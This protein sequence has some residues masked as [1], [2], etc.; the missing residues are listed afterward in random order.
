MLHN[1]GGVTQGG[2]HGP[3]SHNV[4]ADEGPGLASLGR[5]AAPGLFRIGRFVVAALD[6]AD[7]RVLCAYSHAEVQKSLKLAVGHY[8]KQF[9]HVNATNIVTLIYDPPD[10]IR[11]NNGDTFYT[12][13]DEPGNLY[14]SWTAG[15]SS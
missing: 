4:C 2:V 12:R 3:Q 7:D 10:V 9:L 15:H 13:T 11:Y 8:K 14:S 1:T 5:E 6:F